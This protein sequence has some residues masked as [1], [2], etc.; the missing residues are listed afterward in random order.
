[1]RLIDQLAIH[2]DEWPT[3]TIA[4]TQSDDRWLAGFFCLNG[5]WIISEIDV[6]TWKAEDWNEAVVTKEQWSEVREYRYKN[7]GS[8]SE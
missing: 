4:I 8:V 7:K 6:A 1:M 5:E 2:L 3:E